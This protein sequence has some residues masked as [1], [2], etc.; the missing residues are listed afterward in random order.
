M[1][2]SIAAMLLPD[3]EAQVVSVEFIEEMEK[4]LGDVGRGRDFPMS[5]SRSRTLHQQSDRVTEDRSNSVAQPLP[6]VRQSQPCCETSRADVALT[7]DCAFSRTLLINCYTIEVCFFIPGRQQNLVPNHPDGYP[8]PPPFRHN[9]DTPNRHRASLSV[10]PSCALRAGYT[11]QPIGSRPRPLTVAGAVLTDTTNQTGASADY[12]AMGPYETD[13]TTTN[14]FVT[15]SDT[16][17]SQPR[18]EWQQLRAQMLPLLVSDR[19]MSS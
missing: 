12:P 18:V 4:L 7:P 1:L 5:R 3:S 17:A 11:G 6:R 8:R 19:T 2:R 13:A 10:N 15:D 9:W 14:T 16:S